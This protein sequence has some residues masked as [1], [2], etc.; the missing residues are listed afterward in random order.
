M[1][2][3]V[4]MCALPS[5]WLF[6]MQP[7][8]LLCPWDFSGDNSGLGCHFLLWGNLPDPGQT[9]VSWVFCIAGNFFISEPSALSW[10]IFWIKKW[11]C[12]RKSVEGH[13][14]NYYYLQIFASNSCPIGYKFEHVIWF[15][16]WMFQNQHVDQF[17]LFC[18][19]M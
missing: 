17:F 15:D 19:D 9:H 14:R 8:R 13:G 4:L 16:Q 2:C 7:T 12:K 1:H 10:K 18:H 5:L 3:L 6:G 11:L